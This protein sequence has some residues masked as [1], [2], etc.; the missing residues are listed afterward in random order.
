MKLVAKI[1]ALYFLLGGLMP[2]SDFSQIGK[3]SSLLEHYQL[4]RQIAQHEGKEL[5]FTSFLAAHFWQP[6]DHQHNDGGQSH[7]DLPLKNVHVFSHILSEPTPLQL[8][9]PIMGL[10]LHGFEHNNIQPASY[11]GAISRPPIVS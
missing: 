11:S 6:T 8:S 9:L 5:A 7:Q 3:L 2:G 1:L 4:H 10:A